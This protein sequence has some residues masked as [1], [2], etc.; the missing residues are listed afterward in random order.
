MQNYSETPSFTFLF[1]RA[2]RPHRRGRAAASRHMSAVIA[3]RK[4]SS[5]PAIG[6]AGDAEAPAR[7]RQ[8]IL[9]K[10]I[11][12]NASE[13]ARK[14]GKATLDLVIGLLHKRPA[15]W[16][17]A[18]V[19]WRLPLRELGCLRSWRGGMTSG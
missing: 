4:S 17:D 13:Q 14:H 19:R 3:A 7:F 11:V 8:P 5:N 18:A 1:G 15:M 12:L 10:A 16:R 6:P 9:V 2:N